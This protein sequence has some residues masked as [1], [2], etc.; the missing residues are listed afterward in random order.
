MSKLGFNISLQRLDEAKKKFL[1]EGMKLAQEEIKS[2]FDN[3]EDAETGKKW[4]DVVRGVPPPIL[5]ETGLLKR[6]ALKK[7]NINYYLRGN[8]SRAVL[9]IDPINSRTGDGY[10]MPHQKGFYNVLFD[11]MVA[12]RPFVTQSGKLTRLQD[13][14][15][16][17]VFDKI[18]D[19]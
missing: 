12:A 13:T 9:T 7:S 6:E 10:A 18:F 1:E 2:N 19:Y 16:N 17:T 3:Q 11:V 15:F 5:E 8:D 14:L 4:K